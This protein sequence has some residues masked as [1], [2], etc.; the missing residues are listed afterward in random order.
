[1]KGFSGLWSLKGRRDAVVWSMMGLVMF[2]LE[3]LHV[4]GGSHR[5]G[6]PGFWVFSFPVVSLI[7]S[8]AL[9]I[10]QSLAMIDH[11]LSHIRVIMREVLGFWGSTSPNCDWLS[12]Q[13][14]TDQTEPDRQATWWRP[15]IPAQQTRSERGVKSSLF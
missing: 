1:M 13:E 7:D 14:F 8:G 4:S 10:A 2:G 9:D 15:A 12:F 5:W 3:A 11:D 6:V